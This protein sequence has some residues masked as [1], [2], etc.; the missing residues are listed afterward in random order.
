MARFLQR[1][2]LAIIVLAIA[3]GVWAGNEFKLPDFNWPMMF[4]VIFSGG[5]LGLLTFAVGNIMETV[6]AI[7]EKH[8]VS[9]VAPSKGLGAVLVD[10]LGKL[11]DGDVTCPYCGDTYPSDYTNCPHCK[12]KG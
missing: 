5:L 12:N 11:P 3:G 6:N 8:G 10:K 4:G 9:G 2:G 1:L 7:A